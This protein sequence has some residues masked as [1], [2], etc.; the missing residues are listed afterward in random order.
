MLR[1]GSAGRN[2]WSLVDTSLHERHRW[3]SAATIVAGV[4]YLGW[5]LFATLDG[6]PA[7]L[8]WAALVVE[9]LGVLGVVVLL[10][11]LRRSPLH[12]GPLRSGEL[13]TGQEHTGE[14][15]HA[16]AKADVILRVE[17]EPLGRIAA[18]IAGTR[19][20]TN[21]AS[22]TILT[23]TERDDVR[24]L[25]AEHGLDVYYVDPEVDATGLRMAQRV[26]KSPFL[27]L[28]DAGDVP[29][30]KMADVLVRHA[31]DGRVAGVR[32]AVDSWTTDSA[33]H[34][35]RGRHVLRFEREVLYPAAGRA[36]VLQGSGVLLRRWA[37]EHVGVPSGA[38]R[39][40]ELRLSMRLRAAGLEVVAPA[41]PVLVSTYA[42][43]TASAVALERRRDTAA[44]LRMLGSKDG[45]LLAGGLRLGDRIALLST[46]VRP[47]SG[48]RRAMFLVVLLAALMMGE[49]PM[50]AGLVGAAA[51]W[52]PWITLQAIALRRASHTRLD[53][54][55][56]ARW[57]F[58]TMGPSMAA[59]FGAGD[60]VIG[61]GRM[62]PRHGALREFASNRPIAIALGGLAVVV[63]LIAVSDRFTG[64]LPPMASAQRAVLLGVTVWAIAVMLDVV[65]CLNG[66]RQLRRSSRIATEFAGTIS[67]AG[68]TIVDL[69][70]YG[71]G[72]VSDEPVEVGTTVTLHF[73]VPSVT[74]RTS[75]VA[76]GIVRSM[77]ESVYGA[78]SG[79]EFTSM[80]DASSDA[81]YEYCEVVH[82]QGLFAAKPTTRAERRQVAAMPRVTLPP[83][84]MGIRLSAVMVLAGVAVATAPPF[85]T[86]E[87]A[88]VASGGTITV[89]AFQDHNANG[90]RDLI[91]DT[92]APAVDAGVDG[93]TITATCVTD[94]GDAVAGT[95]DGE[96]FAAPVMAT[97]TG[98]GTYTF[99]S[100][101][102]S[103]C[104][105]EAT[106]LPDGFEPGPLG[107]D[108]GGL[109][110]FADAGAEVLM[111]VNRPEEFCQDNPTLVT[112]C[113]TFGDPVDGA[114][115]D[116]GT[117]KAFSYHASGSL[118]GGP[119]PSETPA[120]LAPNRE[121]GSTFGLEYQRATRT[122]YLSAFTKVYAGFGPGGAGAIYTIDPATGGASLWATIPDAG[123]L[124][125]RDGFAPNP[126]SVSG[127]WLQDGQHWDAVGT[128][129]LGGI[130]LSPDGSTLWVV[131]L[132]NRRLY[133][134][135]TASAVVGTPVAIPL[136]LGA[137]GTC[138]ADLV[139]PFGLGSN[140][141][142]LLVG[143]VCSGP[144]TADLRMYVYRFD[145][146][147][148]TFTAAPV[149]ESSLVY[150]RGR[151]G[152]NCGP[153][154]ALGNWNAWADR[155]VFDGSSAP[156]Y[157]AFTQ[158]MLCDIE[159]DDD[160]SLILG[161]RDRFGDQAGEDVPP[162]SN[163]GGGE[164]VS[165][166]DILRAC[167]NGTGGW[168][169]ESNGVCG[170]ATSSAIGATQGPGGKEFYSD[171]FAT[172]TGAGTNHQE[173]SAGGLAKVPG[174]S[175]MAHTVFDPSTTNGGDWRSGGIRRNSN[176]TGL[177]TG[178]F[179]L[180]DKC[181][182]SGMSCPSDRTKTLTFGKVNGLG[183]LVALCDLAPLEVGNRV[184]SDENGN[185]VQDAG[186]PA[187]P[188]VP[189]SLALGS[190]TYTVVT[191][192]N[193]VY[194]FS[195]D[196][197]F[198]DSP[199]AEFGVPQ[200]DE[201][202]SATITFPTSV[203]IGG[204]Q[205]PIT[206]RD[207][208][209]A[210]SAGDTD[211]TVDSD[212]DET[213]GEVTID[214]G[215]A[216]ANDHSYDVGYASRYSLGDFVWDDRNN[217]GV[218]QVG[219]PGIDGVTVRLSADAD[220]NGLP[221]GAALAA[222]TTSDGG[223][224]LFTDLATGTYVVEVV[225]PTGFRSSTG[226]N[227]AATGP[228]EGAATPDPDTVAIDSDDNGS[229]TD[230]TA[231]VVRSLS[232]TLGAFEPLGEPPTPG[233][234]DDTEDD[235]SNATV[236]FGFFRPMSVG[237]LV[238]GD[239][240]NSGT[241]DD[242][243]PGIAGV[244]VLLRQGE[245]VLAVT[246]TD[247][248]GHYLF[249]LLSAGR[250]EVEI[251][252]P[253]GYRSSTGNDS[254]PAPDPD[255]DI[256]DDDDNGTSVEPN[257]A[258]RSSTLDLTPST[259]PSGDD[260]TRPAGSTDPATDDDANYTV[261]FGLWRPVTIGNLVWHD[262][263]DNGIFDVGE[264]GLANIAVALF[265]ADGTTEITVGPDGMLGTLDDAEGG[266]LTD[267]NGRYAFTDLVPDTYRVR[268]DVPA[269]WRTATGADA[270]DANDDTDH[271]NNGGSRSVGQVLA[272][273]VEIA[274]DTEPVNDGDADANS[275][276][277]VDVGL[278][279]PLPV[280]TLGK[281][282]NGCDADVPTG[283]DGPSGGCPPGNGTTNPVVATGAAVTWTYVAANEGNVP[284]EN[285]RITDDRIDQDLIDCNAGADG[286]GQP[287]AI[288]VGGSLTCTA[289]GVAEPGQYA[290][291]AT[292]DADAETS[293]ANSTALAAVNDASHYFGAEPG[294][295]IKT[296]T[297]IADPG[298]APDGVLA[299]PGP[300]VNTTDDADVPGGSDMVANHVVP[301]GSPV[302]WA[303]AVTNTGTVDLVDVQ[304]VDDR[305]GTVCQGL[306]VAAGTTVW[307]ARPGQ[308]VLAATS[309]G[310]YANVGSASGVDLV[311]NPSIATSVGPVSDPTHAFVPTPAISIEKY[312]NDVD[313][314]T[315]ATR[316]TLDAG[317]G[318]VWRYVITN[319]GDWPLSAIVVA[320]DLEGSVSCPVLPGTPSRLLAGQSVTCTE[321]GVVEAQF[322]GVDYVNIG[323][324]TGSPM[325]PS[326][327]SLP[328]PTADDPSG[329]RPLVAAIGDR[330]W[331]DADVDGVQDTDETG[332]GGVTVRLLTPDDLV[333]A[334]TTTDT[335]GV[336][337]FDALDPGTYLLEFAPPP[338]H[339][340]TDPSASFD[341]TVDSD[342]DSGTRR[343]LPTR[344]DGGE[345]DTSW[346][347]GL[348]QLASLGDRVW[349]DRDL[350]GVQDTDESA[351]V[352]TTVRLFTAGGAAIA[353][354]VTDSEGRY[355]FTDL[356]P[357]GYVVQVEVPDGFT[358]TIRDAGGDDATDSDAAVDTGQ[359]H[360]VELSS[361]ENDP[362]I[363]A[364]IFERA[365]IGDRVW[366]DRDHDGVQDTGEAGVPGV[367]VSLYGPDGVALDSV[368]T[369][370]DGT[371]AF[372]GLQPGSY[373]I[374]VSD[375]PSGMTVTMADRG[376]GGG[377]DNAD[378]TDSDA[379]PAT[380]RTPLTDLAPGE[381]DTRWDVGI[382]QP[383]A[384]NP[385][386][387]ET[388][389]TAVL[390]TPGTP[391]TPG[392]TAVAGLPVT[393]GNVIQLLV[394]ASSLLMGG[395]LFLRAR[396]PRTL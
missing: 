71:A 326:V 198:V 246:T 192:A 199:S 363:D 15:P 290:H 189:V 140:G 18:T 297:L 109:V 99:G 360:L 362:T 377:V 119:T 100:L 157:C 4:A 97:A 154:G 81:L 155:N 16:T 76:E 106:V 59:L 218:F 11:A 223:H 91:G 66:T 350:D 289:T 211:D 344:L 338:D 47:L 39:T 375:L 75:I 321:T 328:S 61:A 221:D 386:R 33:E 313:A 301:D 395:L 314:D 346:D 53:W 38:R 166:G 30:P 276:L 181:D 52:L 209:G 23:F 187:V 177:A 230:A 142:D 316:P 175:T 368:I 151:P 279:Q 394:F 87:A 203:T 310:Q 285:A 28:L 129:S 146:V 165:G 147:A 341:G 168:L 277:S 239:A 185:G 381:N 233:H 287:F 349:F 78:V 286:N 339:F 98:N 118:W 379:D 283:S 72:A 306:T 190:S 148:A 269:G 329:Y 266:M 112:T 265:A 94:D 20:A 222:R 74:D 255:A 296:Y 298:A 234:N 212:A 303:Y 393:G 68:A 380:N 163:G 167:P 318:V 216:G 251:F 355:G 336:Y 262:V 267:S 257:G 6:V 188:G 67:G 90:V 382:H 327:G 54:G 3:L 389:S 210:S 144:T 103:P 35:A 79:I 342:V 10:L 50:N 82:S 241:V 258:V 24:A 237:N 242:D 206:K 58:A 325:P 101:T 311:S 123:E 256:D 80:D 88:P 299:G 31:Y 105:I 268:V 134:V 228:Y 136:G 171:G 371:Y 40:V 343:T 8:A 127:D 374:G 49:L 65:R 378:A 104:R 9:A 357:G 183:D 122:L 224:Y 340:V 138:D 250:Y 128:T 92:A 2:G 56:R 231:T 320:D 93:L 170:G 358:I 356:R 69:T 324:V 213:T 55:D 115:Q 229:S 17:A 57:S 254:E 331:L 293:P 195:S 191:D 200:M 322:G 135:D 111:G 137:T 219:E 396:R 352:G 391:D 270:G 36:A 64:W 367:V 19:H 364:G 96:T 319:T 139:R 130:R 369:A 359:S 383:P 102:G 41:D 121:V 21:V 353:S 126:D 1:Q 347:L 22:T 162:G 215:G 85:D 384:S 304:V 238:W 156:T 334:T 113:A 373:S 220:D 307:C 240:D 205:R 25:A 160:G 376:S 259:E 180:F 12:T 117:V 275:N 44:V 46:C 107:A 225:A 388:T 13:H 131:N 133:P 227:T 271:D 110:Q 253:A 196:A 207:V 372:S 164:G 178:F 315:P 125:A 62:Q 176:R 153:N 317:A 248:D 86:T 172:P 333:V 278:F 29:M 37:I 294:L 32:G 281:A 114:T 245:A 260:D 295:A 236:D 169:L 5:R 361:G 264:G 193:G 158:P 182:S 45:P 272:G 204:V 152:N 208:S 288:P 150:T 308:L 27:I 387:P 284:L 179:Q 149:F 7:L 201:G 351:V 161:L 366:E 392:T 202:A 273:H 174:F 390:T 14:L 124:P 348:Y 291:T 263:D 337:R 34:D 244:V 247:I 261:D 89:R 354:D 63:P 292:L 43:N 26:G 77:R 214:F 365:A 282:T 232:V 323:S 143:S 70:P 120:V 345:T 95:G 274:V 243:E 335:S 186:E 300:L 217:D 116:F 252:T 159:I 83:R 280:M 302:W 60:P 226:Q 385:G 108:N 309:S 51:F 249:P 184:W 141:S 370:D 305:A 73:D 332:V 145:P 132:N 330:A 194:R 197:R 48:I 42:A 173:I 235:R 84:R 312:T